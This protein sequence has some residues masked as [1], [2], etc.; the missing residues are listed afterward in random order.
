MRQCNQVSF[1]ISVHS[2]RFLALPAAARASPQDRHTPSQIALRSV[3]ICSGPAS[4]RAARTTLHEIVRRNKTR[5]SP[6]FFQE[7]FARTSGPAPGAGSG[8][9]DGQCSRT[10]TTRKENATATAISVTGKNERFSLSSAA[11]AV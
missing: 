10:A 6:T 8:T 1:F 5:K 11:S 2:P 7:A 3:A 4:E 9:I